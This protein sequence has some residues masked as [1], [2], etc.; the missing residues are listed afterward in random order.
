MED[1]KIIELYLERSEHAISCT[2]EKYHNYL[3]TIAYNIV[4]NKED[5]DECLNDVYMKV[6]QQ[7]PPN[8]PTRFLVWMSKITRNVAIDVYRK[9]QTLRRGGGETKVL[10]DE[11]EGCLPAR[12][13]VESIVEQHQM[14]EYLDKYLH[15][16]NEINRKIFLRRYWYGDSISDIA[17][18]YGLSESAVKSKL[19]RTR[20][21][22]RN[23]LEKEG[24][25]I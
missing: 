24:V 12:D 2:Q 15:H 11:L 5:A 1:G 19:L 20:N 6:W 23:Y 3:F 4:K 14:V 10:L 13:G 7:I 8:R 25:T 16:C 17:I 22:L 18:L 9:N 21:E